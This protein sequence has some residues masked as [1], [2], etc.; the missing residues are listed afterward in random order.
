MTAK[1]TPVDPLSVL[2][3]IQT[4]VSQFLLADLEYEFTIDRE[5]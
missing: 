2:I 1:Q 4:A 5:L 3:F